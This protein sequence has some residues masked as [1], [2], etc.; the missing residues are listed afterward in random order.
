MIRLIF[1]HIA[2]FLANTIY[3]V[4]F[5]FAKDVMPDYITPTGFILLRV[6]AA[7]IIFFVIH[8]FFI[9]EKLQKKDT[10]YLFMC[11]IFGIVINMLCFFKGLNLTSP[12]NASLIMITTP[13][14]V[15]VLSLLIKKEI[16]SYSK[17][18]GVIFGLLGAAMLV[19]DGVFNFQI[20]NLGDLLVLLNAISYGIYLILIKSM[21]SKYHPITV[22]KNLFLLG[23]LILI[24][25]GWVDVYQINFADMPFEII[26]K[27]LFVLLF[28]TCIAYFLNIYAISK[29]SSS[30]VAFYIY[31][32]P[33]LATTLAI[34]LRK[35]L[36]TDLKLLSAL[37]IFLGVYFV[38]KRGKK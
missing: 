7:A 4:N 8:F 2:L 22:L 5:L 34:I 28:T 6:S 17:L 36:L 1:P 33:L 32:Q 24:P 13:L 38:I 10:L 19:T 37:L 26:L 21:M 15:Y 9:K 27:T 18:T 16:Y 29:V 14:I 35:D 12:I 3:A 20:N 30:T 31:L 11:A 23:L 25:I